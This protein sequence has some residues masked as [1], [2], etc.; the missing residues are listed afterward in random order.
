MNIR[1][2]IRR[3]C[4]TYIGAFLAV[5]IIMLA[6][7]VLIVFTVIAELFTGVADGVKRSIYNMK[8]ELHGALE[9]MTQICNP[10]S[11][12]KLALDALAGDKQED[13]KTETGEEVKDN[14]R[15]F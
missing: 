3:V 2:A 15:V 6:F 4:A 13:P 8:Y 10:F 12:R 11:L 5:P 9:V 7:V 1:H 14:E